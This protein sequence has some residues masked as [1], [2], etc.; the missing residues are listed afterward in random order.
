MTNT[1][2]DA[3]GLATLVNCPN[4]RQ[5]HLQGTKLT[6]DDFAK[7]E[8]LKRLSFLWLDSS[9]VTDD[10]GFIA[11]LPSVHTLSIHGKGLKNIERL[12]QFKNLS[13]VGFTDTE[14]IPQEVIESLQKQ[15]PL[16]TIRFV[17]DSKS[18]RLET[19]GVDPVPIAAKQLVTDG[20][21]LLHGNDTEWQPGSPIGW[22]TIKKVHAPLGRK[23]TQ[24]DFDLLATLGLGDFYVLR[25]AD[26]SNLDNLPEF[27]RGR[28][29]GHLALSRTALDDE[30]LLEIGESS[31]IGTIMLLDTKVTPAGVRAFQ[32]LQPGCQVRASFGN[33]PAEHCLPGESAHADAPLG[34]SRLE[35]DPS[36]GELVPNKFSVVGSQSVGVAMSVPDE[37]ELT[38]TAARISTKVEGFGVRLQVQAVPYWPCSVAG[39]AISPPSN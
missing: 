22:L 26:C 35:L 23:L 14:E 24:R 17:S 39:T 7:L 36:S 29:V 18:N 32:N 25:L 13:A 11:K 15:N 20:W 19:L 21:Q 9:Q 1:S 10:W 6:S 27:L 30:M 2:L 31:L 8:S 12:G 5:L 37:Y 4:V 38:F 33:F 34:F 28:K 16:L 3:E